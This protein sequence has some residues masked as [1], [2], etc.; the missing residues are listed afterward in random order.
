MN[1]TLTAWRR[2]LVSMPAVAA[3]ALAWA[4]PGSAAPAPPATPI[5]HVVVI[6]LENHSFDN[7]LGYWCGAHPGRCPD[8]G[9]PASV[10]LSN[11]AVITP[12]VMPD[13]VP[14]VNH[15]V[16]SQL[17]AMHIVGGVPLMDGWQ[18]IKAGGCAATTTPPYACIGGYAPRHI[19]NIT[20]LA[21]EFA[22]SDKTFSMADSPS[23]GGHL[24]AAMASQDGFL[25]DNPVPAPGVAPGPG[26]GCDSNKVTPWLAP[27][28]TLETVPSCIPDNALHLPHGGAFKN[29]PAS[30]LPTIF[31]R[32]DTARLSWKIYGPASPS[33]GGY[34]W[35]ICPSLAECQDTAQRT[36]LVEPTQFFTDA[37][38]GRLP[39]F[40]IVTA[41]GAGNLT[42]SSCH[43]KFSMTA[44]DNYVGRLVSAAEHSPDWSSTAVLL[45]WDD[46]GC[47]Y[48]Q[49][50]PG[51]NPDGTRQG[52][53]VPLII[54]SPY[55][56][57]GY[58]DTTASTFAGILAYTEHTFGLPPLGVNDAHA[59]D[60]SNAFNYTQPP[61]KPLTMITRPL[62]ASAKRIHLTPA[63]LN[64]PS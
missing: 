30:Y 60:F 13:T 54:V 35:A 25:G 20:N 8:G 10:R 43:N 7:V 16:A 44:C 56:K 27:G 46:C 22:I 48:D 58:T 59:Y 32:L 24:Y 14:D 61:L 21:T 34:D 53:R 33:D 62:P 3:V 45:T 26:W 52:P 38:A 50:R 12:Y 47:F 2:L 51:V 15:T 1:V 42:L 41:G 31:D 18:N 37:A 4:V 29:T 64:D 36:N 17:T 55:A 6:Y 39:A 63:L 5:R 19:P 9:M 40:S 28:G 49:V 11:G 23:W 57:P